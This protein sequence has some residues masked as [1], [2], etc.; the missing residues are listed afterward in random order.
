MKKA[1]VMVDDYKVDYF[2]K[3][4]NDKGFEN[5]EQ[6]PFMKGVTALFVSFEEHRANELANTVKLLESNYQRRN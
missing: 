4:L 5:I 3:D 6:K 2:I 1:G